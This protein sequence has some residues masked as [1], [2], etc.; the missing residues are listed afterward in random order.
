[1]HEIIDNIDYNRKSKVSNINT[2]LNRLIE[3]GLVSKKVLTINQRRGKTRETAYCM[4]KENRELAKNILFD[5]YYGKKLLN[6][7]LKR[8]QYRIN[9]RQLATADKKLNLGILDIFKI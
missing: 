1:M 9:S 2:S 6:F 3:K 7:L 8:K 5:L 4:S